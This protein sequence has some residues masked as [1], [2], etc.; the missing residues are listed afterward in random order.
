MATTKHPDRWEDY[1]F[2]NASFLQTA[3]TRLYAYETGD[4]N[5]SRA[6]ISSWSLSWSTWYIFASAFHTLVP[7]RCEQLSI[8]I[9]IFAFK[10]QEWTISSASIRDD[11]S[12]LFAFFS[13]KARWVS[14]TSHNFV[15]SKNTCT[16]VLPLIKTISQPSWASGTTASN[17]VQAQ[18][19]KS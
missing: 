8:A 9:L 13:S 2:R 19:I 3:C 1:M 5:R 17:G 7:S 12:C 18:E 6:C 4:Y 14:C 11:C 16:T 15:R 10:S